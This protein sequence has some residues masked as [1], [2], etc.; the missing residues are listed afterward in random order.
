ML[1]AK[2][3]T[4]AA[5]TNTFVKMVFLIFLN[6]FIAASTISIETAT[7]IPLKAFAM[8]AIS[9]K[10]SRNSEIRKTM[11]KELKPVQAAAIKSDAAGI[12]LINDGK[13]L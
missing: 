3:K 6:I 5:A 7:L 9:R 4:K 2:S 8:I 1:K 10:L 12:P 11:Q 13:T